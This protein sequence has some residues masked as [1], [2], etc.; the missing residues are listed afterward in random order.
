MLRTLLTI[1][2]AAAVALSSTAGCDAKTTGNFNVPEPTVT[3]HDA[4]VDHFNETDTRT[5]KEQVLV[6]DKYF[7]A[8]GSKSNSPLFI[9][10]GGEGPVRG[11]Y[12]HDGIAF[13]IAALHGGIV[14]S[15]EHRFYGKSLPFGKDSWTREN[16]RMLT[17]QQ[18][19]ADYADVIATIKKQ[20]NLA[21]SPESFVVSVGGSYPGELASYLRITDKV[22]GALASSAPV[23]YR[24]F[25][26]HGTKSGAFFQTTTDSFAR[27]DKSCPDRVRSAFKEIQSA[28]TTPAGR[29][30]M[31]SRLGL[32]NPA[33]AAE[34][35]KFD[36]IQ[37]WAESA[38]ATLVMENYPYAIEPFPAWPMNV[39][40]QNMV[41]AG[42]DTIA[43][44][45][46]ALGV[47]Y[48]V[49][50][51]PVQCHDVRAEYYECADITGCGTP[52]TKKH[53]GGDGVSWN[54][55]FC[56]QVNCNADT[57]GVTDMFPARPFNFAHLAQYCLDTFGVTPSP[58]DLAKRY[59]SA[60]GTRI[61]YPNGNIDGW[62]QGGIL[63][64]RPTD[65]VTSVNV[66]LGAH[67]FDLR[68][69]NVEDTKGVRKARA[70]ERKIVTRWL[71][72]AAEEVAASKKMMKK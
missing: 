10:C 23:R 37:L 48:N 72:E 65:D 56:T 39:A 61:I 64:S 1:A 12:N 9:I 67:H 42:E 8:A 35:Y 63:H 24:P 19:L 44:L 36:L 32:C 59:P 16:L 5:Y 41:A 26:P 13:E 68:G 18:A 6:Y 28:W 66:T 38:F 58:L 33:K 4:K 20:Y 43:G 60:S 54:Y 30:A 31:S 21:A 53:P 11:G 62:Y 14:I 40:C 70:I 25:L 50:S 71:S 17:V 46:A 49:T 52:P 51:A 69:D 55:Q 47:A 15:P 27:A 29:V 3:W 34:M 2:A 22:D 57:N 45:R 7:K